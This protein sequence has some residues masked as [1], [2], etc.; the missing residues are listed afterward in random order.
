[1]QYGIFQW[2]AHHL[3]PYLLQKFYECHF[4]AKQTPAAKPVIAS[5]LLVR[6]LN[7]EPGH[8]FGS[9]TKQIPER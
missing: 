3:R 9:K 1:M 8:H 4:Y 6:I 2:L 7:H 5:D